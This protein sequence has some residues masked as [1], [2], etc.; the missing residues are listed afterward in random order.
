MPLKNGVV[1]VHICNKAAFGVIEQMAN[2]RSIVRYFYR[3]NMFHHYSGI[4]CNIT[5]LSL[6]W[7]EV[8]I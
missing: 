8:N 7:K 5:E 3:G 4:F 1:V 2:N 6:L